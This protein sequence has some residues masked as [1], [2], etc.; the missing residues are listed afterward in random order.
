MST[1]SLEQACAA[2]ERVKELWGH[3][4]SLV[5]V[6]IN[7]VD[8]GFGVKVNLSESAPTGTSLP[9]SIDGVPISIEMVGPIHKR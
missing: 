7:R 8:G 9:E 6:G 5:G 4:P 2:K 1:A 3:I